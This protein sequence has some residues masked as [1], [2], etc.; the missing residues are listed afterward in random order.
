MD[1]NWIHEPT[2][3]KRFQREDKSFQMEAPTRGAL[4]ALTKSQRA[5]PTPLRTTGT[6]CAPSRGVTGDHLM[7]RPISSIPFV[8]NNVWLFLARSA[9]LPADISNWKRNSKWRKFFLSILR[10]IRYAQ[11]AFGLP[12]GS[13]GKEAACSVGELGLIPGLGISPGEGNGNPLQYHCLE[14]LMDR[15]AWWATVHEVAKSWTQLSKFHCQYAFSWASL[16][17]SGK[18]SSCQYRKIPWTEESGRLQSMESQ[19]VGH[20]LATKY[21]T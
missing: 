11:C 19:R 18:E 12:G 21:R 13:V 4:G 7:Q 1:W 8:Q 20:V 3:N 2:N 14:N 15:G 10:W 6:D 5:W 9:H 16:G 17:L